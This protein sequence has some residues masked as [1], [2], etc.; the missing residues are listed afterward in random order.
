[1]TCRE[2]AKLKV[3]AARAPL[4]ESVPRPGL[5]PDAQHA[6][7]QSS[8]VGPAC[9]APA[10]T[11]RPYRQSVPHIPTTVMHR[12]RGASSYGRGT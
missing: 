7:Q 9:P 11:T 5:P 2:H 3:T 4:E 8:A 10:T 6:A 12:M 1:M